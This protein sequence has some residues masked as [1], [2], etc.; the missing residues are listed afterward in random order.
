MTVE[1]IPTLN[2]RCTCAEVI[3][4]SDVERLH[5]LMNAGMDQRPASLL[6]WREGEERSRSIRDQFR[7]WFP[8][9]RL[10]EDAA[11]AIVGAS[12]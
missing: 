2:Q 6:L 10:P 12:A 3:G 1:P 7:E 11:D 5:A 4:D 8:W 9:L